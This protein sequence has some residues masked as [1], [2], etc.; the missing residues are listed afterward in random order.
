MIFAVSENK[1]EI[2]RLNNLAKLDTIDQIPKT[3]V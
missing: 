1:G 3:N 2:F